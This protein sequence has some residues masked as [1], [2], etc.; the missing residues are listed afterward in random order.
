MPPDSQ[1]PC[2]CDPGLRRYKMDK[3]VW[4]TETVSFSMNSRFHSREIMTRDIIGALAM[5]LLFVG[6]VVAS[7]MGQTTP[8]PA[9]PQNPSTQSLQA[10]IDTSTTA[11][12]STTPGGTSPTATTQGIAF[13]RSSSRH[14]SLRSAGQGLPGMRG[15]PPIKGSL[16]YLDP[17]SRYM[18]PRTIG[19][20]F[21]DPLLEGLCD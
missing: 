3:V 20:L 13:I 15:G 5:A 6:G 18:Q 4:R 7:S 14:G 9:N 8:T 2:A 16:G 11:M 19:P 17:A 1:G 10:G 21:C 12:T